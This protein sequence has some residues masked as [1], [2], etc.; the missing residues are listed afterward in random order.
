MMLNKFE[1]VTSLRIKVVMAIQ[2]VKMGL[3]NRFEEILAWKNARKLTL[4]VY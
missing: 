2:G 1:T 3:I 4:L